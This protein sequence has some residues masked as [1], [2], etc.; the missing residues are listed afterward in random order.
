MS[1][2]IARIAR[3]SF[4]R[5]SHKC[6]TPPMAS[7]TTSVNSR[8]HGTVTPS[9][10]KFAPVYAGVT[11]RVSLCQISSATLTIK[12]DSPK[13]SRNVAKIGARTT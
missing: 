7:A 6:I 3:P 2:A 10:V 4:E 13:V 1:I 9:R 5:T 11:A 12:S 8:V